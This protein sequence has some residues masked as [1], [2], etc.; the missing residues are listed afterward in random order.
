MRAYAPVGGKSS[1]VCVV[2]LDV[3]YL[4][5]VFIDLNLTYFLDIVIL[6]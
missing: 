4:F 2:S 5:L 1:A 6:N 3:S